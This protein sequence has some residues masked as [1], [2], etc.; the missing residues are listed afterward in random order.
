MITSVFCRGILSG[1]GDN[2]LPMKV[3]GLGT[4]INLILDPVLIYLYQIKG[5]ALATVISQ[6]VV[7][8]VFAYVMI[9]KKRTYIY[10]NLMNFHF[11]KIIFL[12]ILKLGI[13][14]SLSML[15][16]SFGIF[17]YN[18]ILSMSDYPISAVAAYSTA[19]RIE[20]LF[21]IPLISIATSMVTLVG[22]FSGAK[23]IDLIDKVIIN[24]IKISL[25][26][27][28]SFGIL[29]YFCSHMILPLFTNDIE[30]INIGVGYFRIFS[31]AVPFITMGMICSRVM[32]GLGKAYPM[33]VITC[34]RIIVI[35]CFLAYY[36][37]IY[38]QKPINFAWYA[39]LISCISSS[40]ISV[41]WM[42]SVRKNY[43]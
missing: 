18:T 25:L 20:H 2:I 19:H 13:P 43:R 27:S 22:M 29:F 40:L 17:F 33:F 10:L 35:S 1:E 31:F 26:I 37:I 12:Q 9:F 4:L 30:I 11:N 21:F 15:I 34:L 32:Q 38:L 6:I 36:F 7:F 16:M 39:I 3:L 42:I 8:L 28:C 24:G 14:A 5:A 41:A 23:R